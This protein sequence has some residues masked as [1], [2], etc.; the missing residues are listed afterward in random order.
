MS[1]VQQ[2]STSNVSATLTG[3][4]TPKIT[5]LNIT[6]VNTEFSHALQSN[7]NGSKL[8]TYAHLL[9]LELPEI[10]EVYLGKRSNF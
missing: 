8:Y 9:N 10:D 5:H 7:L 4:T 1:N 2:T 3:A 6:S